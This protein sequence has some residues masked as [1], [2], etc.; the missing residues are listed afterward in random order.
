MLS[1]SSTFVTPM[2]ARWMTHWERGRPHP[3]VP[4]TKQTRS[5][6]YTQWSD[7]TAQSNYPPSALVIVQRPGCVGL[8]HFAQRRQLGRRA[9]LHRRDGYP[10][11]QLAKL[12]LLD[13]SGACSWSAGLLSML[14]TYSLAVT[15]FRTKAMS[16]GSGTVS[17]Y[18]HPLTR[19]SSRRPPG[20]SVTVA[21][22]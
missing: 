12:R 10:R 15:E 8:E 3:P 6:R 11:R 20:G 13:G 7:R 14:P 1:R 18:G 2:Y 9:D 19:A 21:Q 16:H 17:M 4:V 5:S 22:C